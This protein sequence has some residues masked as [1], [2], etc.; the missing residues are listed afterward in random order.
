MSAITEL[1]DHCGSSINSIRK[2]LQANMPAGKKWQNAYFMIALKKAVDDGDLVQMNNTYKLGDALRE[3]VAESSY[4][5]QLEPAYRSLRAGTGTAG[6]LASRLLADS[7]KK[8]VIA[9]LH[10]NALSAAI[11][12]SSDVDDRLKEALLFTVAQKTSTSNFGQFLRTPST[13]TLRRLNRAA[14]PLDGVIFP[15]SSFKVLNGLEK[16]KLSPLSPRHK[17]KW[18]TSN[19]NKNEV[20][21]D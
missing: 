2:H 8:V 4:K 9:Q 17:S 11:A 12:P 20:W 16:G 19:G 10:R 15:V 13:K 5:T 14:A 1:K 21:P 3:K 18:E 7:K 6:D